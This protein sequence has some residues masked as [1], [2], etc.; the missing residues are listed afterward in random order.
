MK[1]ESATGQITARTLLSKIGQTRRKRH[2]IDGAKY[3]KLF[4]FG[5]LDLRQ[6]KAY[7][8]SSKGISISF[9]NDN[10]KISFT[11]SGTYAIT[12]YGVGTSSGS[13]YFKNN[14]VELESLPT[15]YSYIVNGAFTNLRLSGAANT[16]ILS[17]IKLD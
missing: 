13:I 4:W 3:L 2:K 11:N 12:I 16:F 6:S 1:L 5:A 8:L 9:S 15:P 14:A 7:T 17:I 10:F